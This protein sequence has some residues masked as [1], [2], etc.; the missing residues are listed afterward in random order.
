MS[1]VRP[2]GPGPAQEVTASRPRRHGAGTGRRCEGVL[3][4]G[5]WAAPSV[6]SLLW[7]G[8]ESGG[9]EGDLP[10]RPGAARGRRIAEYPELEATYKDRRVQLWAPH[11]TTQSQ[12]L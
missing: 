11:R 9:R 3:A 7:D 6:V 10:Q 8:R 5:L 4:V 2:G 1:Q 12:T